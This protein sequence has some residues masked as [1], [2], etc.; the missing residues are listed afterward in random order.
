MTNL[1]NSDQP[2]S[3]SPDDDA[4]KDGHHGTGARDLKRLLAFL[5]LTFA[6][7][8]ILIW[9]A[10]DDRPAELGSV[11]WRG[12][13]VATPS[14]VAIVLSALDRGPER[15]RFFRRFVQVR[16]AWW[17]T[18]VLFYGLAAC[19]LLVVGFFD[20]QGVVTMV[21]KPATLAVL[22]GLPVFAL[23]TQ[24]IGGPLEEA[25]WR[26]YALPLMLR[27]GSPL[28]ASIVVG[29][30]HAAWHLPLFMLGSYPS[31]DL[32][33]IPFAATLGLFFLHVVNVS[34]LLSWVFLNSRGSIGL[35]VLAHAIVNFTLAGQNIYELT[36]DEALQIPFG[37]TGTV[38]GA[39]TSS[40]AVGALL[41]FAE[42]RRQLLGH[43]EVG[44][45]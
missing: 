12:L 25:G 36:V 10:V 43:S 31:A 32:T 6:I 14:L 42:P 40:A 17:R 13:A 24:G 44:R 38:L 21:S 22:A 30:V 19:F 9:P 2:I 27:F 41:A 45:V 29:V 35:V 18:L 4:E 20:P 37:F 16:M 8:W 34:I 1:H 5:V 33:E 15:R 23:L 39:M 28:T 7:S 26:G 11:G 3:V